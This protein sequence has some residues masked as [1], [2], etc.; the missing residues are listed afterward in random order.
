MHSL[1]T[2]R[3]PVFELGLK[4]YLWGRVALELARVAARIGREQGV[5]ILYTA[6]LVDVAAIAAQMRDELLV[7]SPQVDAVMPGRGSTS[8][9]IL[10][11]A[12]RE[13]G[14]AGALLNHSERPM[15]L[16][17]IARSIRRCDQSGLITVV[18]A[19]SPDEAA[20]LAHLGPNII[21][22]EPPDLIGGNRSVAQVQAEFI[23]RS[24]ESVRGV[25]P[26]ILVLNSAGIRT[27][28]DAAAVIEAGADGTGSTSGVLA[29]ADPADM[30]ERMVRAVRQ[31]WDRRK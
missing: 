13:A 9:C 8:G 15:G 2:L 7:L 11:E 20:A 28:D 26:E 30:L 17:Q 5:T 6:G 10:P 12:L 1:A 27:P 24:V 31:A 21:L 29:S 18:C 23:A 4:G 14:V 25:N 22:A 3:P 19:D 16:G